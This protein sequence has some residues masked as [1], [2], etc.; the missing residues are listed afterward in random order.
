MERN[1]LIGLAQ[2]SVTGH[3]KMVGG[4]VRSGQ[5]GGRLI[6]INIKIPRTKDK[7]NFI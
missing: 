3:E 7:I 2:L 6:F 4:E 5:A 1:Q